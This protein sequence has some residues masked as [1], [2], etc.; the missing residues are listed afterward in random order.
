MIR[1][2]VVSFLSDSAPIGAFTRE[3]FAVIGRAAGKHGSL[4]HLS[5]RATIHAVKEIRP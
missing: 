3:W 2:D 1:V 5:S 4:N